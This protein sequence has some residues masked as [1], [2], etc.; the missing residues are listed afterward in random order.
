MKEAVPT[1]A[2]A[3]KKSTKRK[4]RGAPVVEE[5][6]AV[7]EDAEEVDEDGAKK[8]KTTEEEV[9]API[10]HDPRQAQARSFLGMLDP[11]SLKHPVMPTPA[12]MGQVLLDARKRALR[13]E[14]GV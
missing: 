6:E 9:N 11:E 10:A 12:E 7:P 1:K 13:E 4:T 8:A 3:A 14:Y 5:P 2:A